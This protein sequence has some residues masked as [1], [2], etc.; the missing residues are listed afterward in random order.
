MDSNNQS[1]INVNLNLNINLNINVKLDPQDKNWALVSE[2]KLVDNLFSE[3]ENDLEVKQIK[4]KN[5][6][7]YIV[8]LLDNV[9]VDFEPDP[10][11]RNNVR[12][13]IMGL[14]LCQIL[15]Q[16][17]INLFRK[18]KE[19]REYLASFLMMK[20]QSY[21]INNHELDDW[22]DIILQIFERYK[23]KIRLNDEMN[24]L[25]DSGLNINKIISQDILVSTVLS[26]KRNYIFKKSYEPASYE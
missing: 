10:S 6:I 16:K 4:N 11:Y 26:N 5:T 20:I 12:Y 7:K 9:N 1:D 25:I 15:K 19:D 21:L 22:N 18:G 24:R 17:T 13:M 23:N 8:N 3:I 14:V 2:D